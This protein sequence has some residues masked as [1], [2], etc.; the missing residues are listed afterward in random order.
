MALAYALLA[1]L[2]RESM[3]GYDL[4]KCFDREISCYWI[5]SHQQVYKELRDLAQ[6]AWV[7]VEIIP[8]QGRPNKNLYSITDLGRQHLADWVLEPSEPTSI[9]ETLMVK[10]KAGF[11]VPKPVILQEIER[12]RGVHL[13]SWNELKTMEREFCFPEG[14]PS[15]PKALPYGERLHYLGLQRGIRY[16]AEWVEWCDFAIETLQADEEVL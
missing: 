9:R 16:E 8:Q 12:R 11:L 3:S 2:A 13:N 14:V 4:V 7:N 1:A 10:L 15:D 5:A 6:K